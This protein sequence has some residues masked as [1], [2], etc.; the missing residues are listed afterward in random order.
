MKS[1]DNKILVNKR[2][3]FN[4]NINKKVNGKEKNNKNENE[5]EN[6]DKPKIKIKIKKYPLVYGKTKISIFKENSKVNNQL[7]YYVNKDKKSRNNIYK[8]LL[9]AYV[10]HIKVV[11]K[12][13]TQLIL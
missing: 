7:S 8:L 4:I 3:I 9:I 11:I 12:E 1:I 13:F 5:N 6:D 10:W 2:K